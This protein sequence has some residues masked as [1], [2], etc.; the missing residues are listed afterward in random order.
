MFI[1]EFLKWFEEQSKGHLSCCV[2]SFIEVVF[3]LT[4]APKLKNITFLRF[5]Q[6]KK[7]SNFDTTKYANPVYK[8]GAALMFATALVELVNIIVAFNSSDVNFALKEV[9]MKLAPFNFV[10]VVLWISYY[11]I[12]SY[13]EDREKKF[14]NEVVKEGIGKPS[15]MAL[16][17]LDFCRITS[18]IILFITFL[19]C[20]FGVSKV[21][22]VV[23]AAGAVIAF[24]S[25]RLFN[26]IWGGFMIFVN[27][28]FWLNERVQ[29]I[30]KQ[31]VEVEGV[32]EEIT[33]QSTKIS[34]DDDAYLSLANS[35]IATMGIKN[36]SRKKAK[37]KSIPAI[38]QENKS[39]DKFISK[40]KET[41]MKAFKKQ[42][43]S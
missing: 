7:R 42:K 13:I 10:I 40:I 17:F 22:E 32:V 34:T 30:D 28:P 6:K 29:F 23:G 1:W 8:A 12:I 16:S 14:H 41:I 35:V 3:L 2:I 33:W 27:R 39:S 31:K 15:N 26:N 5:L 20:G 38:E 21:L 19:M 37:M 4:I 25:G 9:N 24:T 18:V 11:R 36:Y 43:V